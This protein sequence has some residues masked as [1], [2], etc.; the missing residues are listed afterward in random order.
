MARYLSPE[1]FAE[2][3]AGSVG[4]PATLVLEEVVSDTPG[5]TIVYRVEVA[6][7]GTRIVWPVPEGAGPADLR[8]STDWTT[9]VSVARGDLSAQR[10]LMEG[11]LRVSGSPVRLGDVATALSGV[12]ALPAAVRGHTTYDGT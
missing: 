10:A 9:A 4:G 3:T 7:D 1:W 6:G 5:G 12:D 8:I 2:A 11:R